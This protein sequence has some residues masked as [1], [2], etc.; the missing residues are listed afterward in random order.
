MG[1]LAHADRLSCRTFANA[2][3][4]E[5]HALA[6]NLGNCM[7]A[8]AMPKAAEALS[9]TS[10]REEPINVAPKSSAMAAMSRSRWP[11]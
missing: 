6:C 8:L 1:L 3:R 7:R 10:L 5:L 2:V 9:L 4:L 11:G